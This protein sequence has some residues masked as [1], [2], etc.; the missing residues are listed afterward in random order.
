MRPATS[1]GSSSMRSRTSAAGYAGH[2]LVRVDRLELGDLTA[3]VLPVRRDAHVR[4][5]L[6][7][8]LVDREALRRRVGELEQRAA[9]R[10][11]VDREEVAAVLDVRDVGE[12]E[13]DDPVLELGLALGRARVPGVVMDRALAEVPRALRQVG[14]LDELDDPPV[15]VVRAD[16][17]LV[18]GTVRAELAGA[19]A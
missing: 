4:A 8:G 17:V 5:E 9:G 11:A 7:G 16:L 10:A 14:L 2:L 19:H 6:V 15:A 13:P 3:A 1:S 12:P 18:V